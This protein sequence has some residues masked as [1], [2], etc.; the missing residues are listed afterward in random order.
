MKSNL[1]RFF[2]RHLS[3]KLVIL[4]LVLLLL[5]ISLTSYLYY[6][7]S[8]E[9][10]SEN[11]RVSTKQSAKQSADYLSLMLTVG[12]DMGRQIFRDVRLQQMIQLEQSGLLSVDQKFEMNKTVDQIL[13]NITYTNSYVRSIYLLKEEGNSWGS[14]LFNVS[15]VKRYTLN[16]QKWYI[17]VVK[18]GA[19]DLWLPLQYDP[20]SGG[21]PNTEL[22]LTLVKPLLNLESNERIGVIVINL[23]GHLLLEA[24]QRIRLGETGQF[25]V[26]HPSGTVMLHP[27]P[28]QWNHDLKD[29]MLGDR[30][31]AI[32]R[33]A[34]EFEIEWEQ[35]R[36][37]VVTQKMENGWM[38]VGMVPVKEVIGEIQQIQRRIWLYS[39]LLLVAASLMGW[40][41]SRRITSPLKQLMV[42]MKEVERSNFQA[43][44]TV[45]SKDE[46][47]LLSRRFNR[48]VGRIKALIDQINQVESKK[49]EA[50]MRALR[51]QIN[52]HFL[53]N[54]LSTIRW[55]VK[56]QRYDGAYR[57]ISA[58]VNLMESSMGKK[59]V[60]TT[61]GEELNLL[62]T[63]MVIQQ[64]RY[65]SHIQLESVCPDRFKNFP[66]PRMLL[67][68]IV[69]NAVFH[70]LAP[71][72][73]GGTIIVSVEENQSGPGVVI[74]IKDS[75]LGIP[76]L[77]LNRLLQTDPHSRSGM[78]G[79]GLRHVHETIQIYYG[80]HSGVSVESEEGV[81]TQVTLMLGE[82]KGD[83][84]I[85]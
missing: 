45:T 71:H 66:I 1:I 80:N 10:V 17:D 5:S 36:Q 55:M 21:G 6:R 56:L 62:E 70:G 29:T 47:G 25:F 7:S 2:N 43:M 20:F 44:T 34:S 49:R 9:L 30:L 83:E 51:Y 24:I 13:N 77:K 22:V 16:E 4:I 59:G 39:T 63:Y 68:P 32:S 41:F 12:S 69:E 72:P 60:F 57:G 54:T 42:Q 35:Q 48:M 85:V 73:K 38:V 75:G 79:I 27:N 58:L 15:K 19:D 18:Q 82:Q 81:G 78:F 31:D 76:S 33:T 67:Q 11:V 65:G 8:S 64:Y 84:Q 3:T 28:E 61:L 53:Y 26:I 40:L 74:R 50:E 23:N 14:G 46:I 37:Y 52:P